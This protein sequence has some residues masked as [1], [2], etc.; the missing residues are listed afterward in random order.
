MRKRRAKRLGSRLSVSL[1]LDQKDAI[2][3][4]ASRSGVPL[5]WVMRRAVERLLER[6]DDLG[7]PPAGK[8]D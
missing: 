6:P 5:A 4:L 2:E 8:G 3:A 7:L 1:T